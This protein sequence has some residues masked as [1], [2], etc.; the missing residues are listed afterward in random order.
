MLRMAEP[1]VAASA[2]FVVR[3]VSATDQGTD[4]FLRELELDDLA[5]G[6]PPL[7][8]APHPDRGG[9]EV[10]GGVGRWQ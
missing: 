8:R 4:G 1:I 2:R 6:L 10:T 3:K 7:A 9:A 5:S